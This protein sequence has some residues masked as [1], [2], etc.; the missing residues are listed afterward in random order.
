MAPMAIRKHVS[1]GTTDTVV[2]LT[3]RGTI[4]CINRGTNDIFFTTDGSTAAVLDAD[5][6]YI[7]AGGA[8]RLADT[9]SETNTITIH[10]IARTGATTAT[11]EVAEHYAPGV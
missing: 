8:E 2:T 11:F 6:T 10:A 5:D 9:N 4:R 3:G 1:V 7:V